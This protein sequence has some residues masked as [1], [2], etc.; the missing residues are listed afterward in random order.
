M[1]P[2]E[3]LLMSESPQTGLDRPETTP[4]S[5]VEAVFTLESAAVCPACRGSLDTVG[6]AHHWTGTEIDLSRIA[7]LEVQTNRGLRSLR[8][9]D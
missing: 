8:A 4:A 9:P 6:I 2:F 3:E 1:Q 5:D 7:R